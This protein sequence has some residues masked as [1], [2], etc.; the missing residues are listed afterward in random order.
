M[1]PRLVPGAAGVLGRLD[2]EHLRCGPAVTA[3]DLEAGTQ[4]VFRFGPVPPER[5]SR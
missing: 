4:V 3:T 5:S 1:T 2:F